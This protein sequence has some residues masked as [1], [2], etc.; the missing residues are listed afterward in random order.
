M[1]TF[2]TVV[3]VSHFFVLYL[4]KIPKH[5]NVLQYH[6]SQKSYIFYLIL[7]PTVKPVNGNQKNILTFT[8]NA[9]EILIVTAKAL[10]IIPCHSKHRL[11]WNIRPTG[12]LI[13][14]INKKWKCKSKDRS[15]GLH[16]L[17]HSLFSARLKTFVNP[18]KKNRVEFL[19]Y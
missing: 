13:R 19:P 2:I 12:Q 18:P 7:V 16:L 17:I 11:N 3:C 6:R 5:V 10:F 1:R 4:L 15:I 8:E 14:K 9:I